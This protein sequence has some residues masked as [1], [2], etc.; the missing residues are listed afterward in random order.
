MSM[1][2]VAHMDTLGRRLAQERKRLGYNQ[3]AKEFGFYI[4]VYQAQQ[5][6]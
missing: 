4:L 5:K 2:K 1:I 3:E 6:E